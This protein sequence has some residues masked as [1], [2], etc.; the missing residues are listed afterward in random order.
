MEYIPEKHRRRLSLWVVILSSLTLALAGVYTLVLGVS[1]RNTETAA[2]FD[3]RGRLLGYSLGLFF[4]TTFFAGWAWA[5]VRKNKHR[6]ATYIYAGML[7]VAAGIFIAIA[8]R[9]PQIKKETH[10]ELVW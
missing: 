7:F 10:H 2:A 3:V 5:V 6:W 8:I 4:L 1:L 9:V